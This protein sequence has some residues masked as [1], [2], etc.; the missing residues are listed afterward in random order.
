MQ[1]GEKEMML[2]YNQMTGVSSYKL[3]RTV[4]VI[5]NVLVNRIEYYNR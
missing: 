4:R 2:F 5:M 1:S 3:R